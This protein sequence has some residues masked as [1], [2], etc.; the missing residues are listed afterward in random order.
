M[1]V[2][3]GVVFLLLFCPMIWEMSAPVA[4]AQAP[5]QARIAANV[6]LVQIP[7]IVLDDKGAVATNLK[8]SDF[9]LSDDGVEQ[10]IL[11]LERERDRGFPFVILA[12]REL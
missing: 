9:R 7:V 12:G 5:T 1:T 11:Y 2:K 6:E 10:R 3:W 4:D 8:K